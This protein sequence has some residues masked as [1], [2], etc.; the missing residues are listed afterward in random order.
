MEVR[1]VIKTEAKKRLGGNWMNALLV[2]LIAGV[3]SMITSLVSNILIEYLVYIRNGTTS[4]QVALDYVS[5]IITIDEYYKYA[6]AQAKFSYINVICTVVGLL[7]GLFTIA[8]AGFFLKITEGNEQK[9][10]TVKDFFKEGRFLESLGLYVIMAL[11]IF[12][13]TL[14]FIIPGI[15]KM[16]SYSMAPYLKYNNPKKSSIDCIHESARIMNGYKGSLFVLI[17]SFIGWFLLGVI[18]SG[19]VDYI[20]G[21]AGTV[22]SSVVYFVI[23]GLLDVYV[24]TCVTIFYR[25]LTSPYLNEKYGAK[26]TRGDN[27]YY[28]G[29]NKSE[30]KAADGTKSGSET[31][32][33]SIEPFAETEKPAEQSDPFAG[34]ESADAKEEKNGN[35]QS[36]NG[37]DV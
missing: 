9:K 36:E 23:M 37:S 25:E 28:Y 1:K 31:A 27:A 26:I 14:L 7:V 4:S 19:F 20:P 22:I 2:V 12:L 35:T 6:A 32:N 24:L 13:W 29:D 34:Y 3:I 30:N 8:Q 33:E 15:V 5:G 21:I 10:V 18:V 17:L 11:K 16:F